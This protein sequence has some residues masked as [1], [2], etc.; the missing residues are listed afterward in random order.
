M[1]RWWILKD[2]LRQGPFSEPE[3]AE[4]V[5]S[6]RFSSSDF[7]VSENSQSV[8]QLSHRTIREVL[9]IQPN[10][11]HSVPSEKVMIVD[12]RNH[13]TRPEDADTMPHIRELIAKIEAVELVDSSDRSQDASLQFQSIQHSQP[14]DLFE[15]S[16]ALLKRGLP[17]LAV[18]VVALMVFAFVDNGGFG[19]FETS[20]NPERRPAVSA[21]P[22]ITPPAP[23]ATKSAPRVI[24]VPKMSQRAVQGFERRKVV[25]PRVEPRQLPEDVPVEETDEIESSRTAEDV[26]VAPDRSIGARRERLRKLRNTMAPGTAAP[27][28]SEESVPGVA[29]DADQ[30]QENYDQ[31]RDI[32]QEGP[33]SY[34]SEEPPYV[35]GE[36]QVE[37]PVPED[38]VD[39]GADV[40]YQE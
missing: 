23:R 7:V 34:D 37:F 6:G 1:K 3:L 18:L 13:E 8:T 11:G 28:I 9:G 40:E 32:G 17:I 31:G 22:A 4:H 30:E 36:E 15:S 24:A 39:A 5:K 29:P 25:A 16:L 10:E 14:Q 35:E 21:T 27:E 2:R 33:S 38:N 12:R 19:D 20:D 26:E